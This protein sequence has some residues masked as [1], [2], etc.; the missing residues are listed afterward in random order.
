MK[1]LQYIAVLS[2]LIC[3]I[4]HAAEAPLFKSRTWTSRSGKTIEAALVKQSRYNAVLEKT[5][6]DTVGISPSALSKEDQLYLIQA[7]EL[8]KYI[9]Q[10]YS[11]EIL[12]CQKLKFECH[13]SGLLFVSTIVDDAGAG[14]DTALIIADP[15]KL[16][17][18]FKKGIE[19]CRTA[20]ENNAESESRAL[21]DSVSTKV[22][23]LDGMSISFSSEIKEIP[24]RGRADALR[25]RSRNGAQGKAEFGGGIGGDITPEVKVAIYKEAFPYTQSAY[26]KLNEKDMK[27]IINAL[28]RVPFQLI[29]EHSEAKEAQSKELFK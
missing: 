6:G 11:T 13:P 4:A 16:I 17:S 26:I 5:D 24:I 28:N 1:T 20:K 18:A 14:S 25:A 29:K 15:Q 8:N 27:T 22:G 7:A 23:C 2:A 12:E 3:S 9:N 21:Y 19:W 10:Q